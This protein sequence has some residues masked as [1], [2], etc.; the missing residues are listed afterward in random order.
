MSWV[1]SEAID[2]CANCEMRRTWINPCRRPNE[3]GTI[4]PVPNPDEADWNEP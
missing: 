3:S 4:I 1:T 2:G